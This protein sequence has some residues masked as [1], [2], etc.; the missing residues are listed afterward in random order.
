MSAEKFRVKLAPE[1][2]EDLYAIES[3]WIGRNEAWRG[4]KY[5]RDLMHKASSELSDPL[6][7]RLG[8]RLKGV[9]FEDAQE[10]L[11]FG[12]YRIIYDIDET[13]GIVNVLR[14]WHSHRDTPGAPA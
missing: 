11:V 13:A 14:F 1:A 3:Y 8:R 10:I 9:L 7:A 4:E 5:F 12:I 6:R 2:V